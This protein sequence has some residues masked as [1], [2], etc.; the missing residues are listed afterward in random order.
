MFLPALGRSSLCESIHG[1]RL[2][3]AA[4]VLGISYLNRTIE[5]G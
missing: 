1:L 3:L 5:L 4:I 2:H